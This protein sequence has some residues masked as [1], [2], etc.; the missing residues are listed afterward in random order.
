MRDTVARANFLLPV[1]L[2]TVPELRLRY[3]VLP[4]LLTLRRIIGFFAN[5]MSL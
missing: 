5:A 4:R 2:S 3:L 1:A